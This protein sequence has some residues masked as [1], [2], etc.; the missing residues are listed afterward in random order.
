MPL[1]EV[2]IMEGRTPQQ[3]REM[4]VG[5]TD[6]VERS[7]DVPRQAI[8]IAIREIPGHHWAIGG[9]QV[10]VEDDPSDPGTPPTE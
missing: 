7:M 4:I 8:R 10:V 1:I 5:I 6:V 2:T 3:K 9:V